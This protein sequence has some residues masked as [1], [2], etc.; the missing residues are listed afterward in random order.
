MPNS[1]FPIGTFTCFLLFRS[2]FSNSRR[3]KR[4]SRQISAVPISYLAKYLLFQS[5]ILPNTCCFKRLSP[6]VYH[7]KRLSLR[8]PASPKKKRRKLSSPIT[9]VLRFVKFH[10][11]P[12]MPEKR[13]TQPVPARQAAD[14]QPLFSCRRSD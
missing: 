12:T 9:C 4:L 5:A 2:Y 14:C 6:N 7:Y 3:S 8:I 10:S 1:Y 11:P 13:H